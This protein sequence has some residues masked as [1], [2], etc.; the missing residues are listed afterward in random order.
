MSQ[1]LL[2]N[3]RVAIKREVQQS[4]AVAIPVEAQ[5]ASSTGEADAVDTNERFGLLG[6][7]I[8][9]HKMRHAMK[10]GLMPFNPGFGNFGYPG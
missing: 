3:G 1:F 5:A 8:A 4:P 2:I 10:H 7:L 9:R 6:A